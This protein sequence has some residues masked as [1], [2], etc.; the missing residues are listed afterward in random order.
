MTVIIK[1]TVTQWNR[2]VFSILS[3]HSATTTS[4]ML[5]HFFRLHINQHRSDNPTEAV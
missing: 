3:I 4:Q 2:P 5:M 1:T